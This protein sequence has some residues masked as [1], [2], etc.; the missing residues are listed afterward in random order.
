MRLCGQRRQ[1]LDIEDKFEIK[2]MVITFNFSN[3]NNPPKEALL[4]LLKAQRL[5]KQF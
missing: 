4:V 2:L 5:L 3:I 1:C